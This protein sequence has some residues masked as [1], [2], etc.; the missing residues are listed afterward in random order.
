MGCRPSDQSG[1][2]N[3]VVLS[4]S[5][6]LSLICLRGFISTLFIFTVALEGVS[7]CALAWEYLRHIRAAS[8]WR[9]GFGSRADSRLLDSGSM[10]EDC[11]GGWGCFYRSIPSGRHIANWRLS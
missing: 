7:I 10:R 5:V 8:Q 9:M 3:E 4:A 2:H 1:I 6:F 11:G